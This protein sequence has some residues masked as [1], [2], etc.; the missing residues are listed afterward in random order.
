MKPSDFPWRRMRSG[1]YCFIP[2][3][4]VYA[5]AVESRVSAARYYGKD[6]V[7][8]IPCVYQGMLGV[9]LKKR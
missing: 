4:D 9:M 6:C 8:A 2:C 3:L 1:E 5:V 7:K